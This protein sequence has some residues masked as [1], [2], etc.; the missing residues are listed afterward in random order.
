MPGQIAQPPDRLR[1]HERRLD[2]AALG[3]LAQP[4]RVQHIR[5]APRQSLDMRGIDQDRLDGLFQQVERAAP[6]LAR[7]LHDDGGDLLTGQIVAQLQQVP[8]RGAEGAHLL[9]A[10]DGLTDRWEPDADD[11]LFLPDVN[12]R[13]PPVQRV[14]PN[15][16]PSI[17]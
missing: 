14:H 1:R 5:L 3:Q 11:Q 10:L 17:R 2:Q 8:R 12:R 7:R 4:D 16:F 9:E 6:V 13:D 15:P